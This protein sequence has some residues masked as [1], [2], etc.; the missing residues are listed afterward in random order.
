MQLLRSRT[1]ALSGLQLGGRLVACENKTPS[2]AN[3]GFTS[4]DS[5]SVA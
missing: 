4:K 3:L 1:G 2:S 5:E